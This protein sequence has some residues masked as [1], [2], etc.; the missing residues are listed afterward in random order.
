M[1]PSNKIRLNKFIAEAGLA[2]RRKADSLIEDGLVMVNGK[3]VFEMGTQIDPQRDRVTVD[4]KP[5]KV[6]SEK[7]Y[8]TFFKPKNVLTSME[9]PEGR[10]TVADFFQELPYR[11]FPVGR[12]DWD[13]EGLLIL[14]NDGDF[15][16][17]VMHPREE[18]PKTYL[19]KLNGQPTEVE[20]EKLKRGVSIIGG[21][22]AAKSVERVRKT[23]A[24]SEKSWLKIVITEGKNR[25]IR[26]MFE[27]IGYDV[28]K[29]QRIAIGGLE[30]RG[31]D[32]GEW[33]MI[34]KKQMEKIFH[35]QDE[36]KNLNRRKTSQKRQQP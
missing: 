11:V 27:K 21:K 26:K 20:L 2:S 25:Q 9:D 16:N 23:G 5:I 13:S 14:T 24:S 18:I 35:S 36:A 10:P 33:V 4:G 3:K 30:L 29:L 6:E 31:L 19:V 32:R 34:P 15:A 22:V 17:R 28:E 12:L 8:I 7:V 1:A